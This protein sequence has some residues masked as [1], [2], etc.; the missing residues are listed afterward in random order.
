M[1]VFH[2]SVLI[3]ILRVF[4][5]SLL[6]NWFRDTPNDAVSP[7]GETSWSRCNTGGKTWEE[8]VTVP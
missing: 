1:R 3:F 2:K 8:N 6:S 4:H 7:V 5:N